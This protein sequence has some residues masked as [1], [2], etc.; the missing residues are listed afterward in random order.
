MQHNY[1]VGYGKPPKKTQFK[2]GCSGNK[3]GRPKGRLNLAT[4]MDELM[5]E[6]LKV[7]QNGKHKKISVL[8]GLLKKLLQE[9]LNGNPKASKMLLDLYEKGES[10]RA[11]LAERN[12]VLRHDDIA[13]LE[14]Y[15]KEFFKGEA[16]DEDAAR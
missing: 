2:P 11:E 8:K 9:A 14:D 15:Y 3:K 10:K 1:E 7:V 12:E 4:L 13:I 16:V 5:S 6:K